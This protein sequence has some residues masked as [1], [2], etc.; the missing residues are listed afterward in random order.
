MEIIQNEKCASLIGDV[1]PLLN[2]IPQLPANPFSSSSPHTM[3]DIPHEVVYGT[4]IHNGIFNTSMKPSPLTPQAPLLLSSQSSFVSGQKSMWHCLSIVCSVWE[5]PGTA[6]LQRAR[7]TNLPI[8]KNITTEGQTNPPT[9][10]GTGRKTDTVALTQTHSQT[11]R[12]EIDT[13]KEESYTRTGALGPKADSTGNLNSCALV[14]V[15]PQ[16]SSSYHSFRT[17]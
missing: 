3:R 7:G 14:M 17:L 16:A 2:S 12:L 8:D 4:G 6:H 10:R 9:D 15:P 5:V 11:H 13:W 1:S